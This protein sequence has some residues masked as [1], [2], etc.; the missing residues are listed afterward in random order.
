MELLETGESAAPTEQATRPAQAA[1]ELEDD[2]QVLSKMLEEESNLEKQATFFKSVLFSDL[3]QP[4]KP[5][6][7]RL[8][9]EKEGQIQDLLNRLTTLQ[10]EFERFRQRLSKEAE[11]A[12][13]FS[14]ESLILQILPILDNLERA[15]AH[16][17]STEEKAAMVQGVRLIHKQLLDVLAGAGLAPIETEG[18]TFDPNYHE[19]IAAVETAESEPNS[20]LSEYQRGYLLYDRLI[21]PSRVIVAGRGPERASQPTPAGRSAGLSGETEGPG[22]ATTGKP[23]R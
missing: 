19:A 3:E 1:S 14:N 2:L 21:R 12:K 5:I 7:E 20:I 15:M 23:E 4:G 9:H 10:G 18:K 16:A 22:Q 17:D 6:D 8:V 11:T 13:R